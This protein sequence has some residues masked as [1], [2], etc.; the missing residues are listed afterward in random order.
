MAF[1]NTNQ[2]ED[3]KYNLKFVDY[4]DNLDCEDLFL[5]TNDLLS[6]DLYKYKLYHIKN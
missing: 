5:K 6:F 2:K 4:E 3:L 1:K